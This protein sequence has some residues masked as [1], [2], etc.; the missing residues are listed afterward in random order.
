MRRYTHLLP[1][2][3]LLTAMPFM[4]G[5]V[6]LI[7]PSTGVENQSSVD[8]MPAGNM[9]NVHGPAMDLPTGDLPTGPV[10]L[11]QNPAVRDQPI[12]PSDIEDKKTTADKK[13]SAKKPAD[14]KTAEKEAAAK[15]KA[16]A[17]SPTKSPTKKAA[18]KPPLE[19]LGPE[20]EALRNRVR[21]AINHYSRQPLD[22][23]NNT[24]DH[25]LKACKAFGCDTVVRQGGASGEPLNGITCLCWNYSC[26][27][28]NL[29]KMVDGHIAARVG[30]GLQ[31]N[32]SE[33]LAVLALARVPSKYPI[34][35]GDTVRTVADLVESEKLDCRSGAD[36]SYRL[37]GLTR[38][39]KANAVWKNSL[40]EKWS[41]SRLLKEELNHAQEPSPRGGTNRLMA[42][43]YAIDRRA[44]RGLPI[45]GQFKR[46]KKYVDQY[47]DYALALQAPN[48]SWHPSFFKYRGEGGSSIDQI[49][50]TGHILAWL[51]SSLPD[52]ELDDPR[53]VR[54]VAFL[55]NMLAGRRQNSLTSSSGADIDARMNA[56]YALKVY[57]RRVFEPYDKAAAEAEAAEPDQSSTD[58]KT[59][60][61]WHK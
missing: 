23:Q 61:T 12:K 17:K 13:A 57:D 48:G 42:I 44:R 22:T 59:V 3:L 51:V 4:L 11:P 41:V 49:N 20:M 45:D 10:I 5:A 35:V 30:Y 32:P 18:A 31:S 19:P 21:Q 52:N 6:V 26:G 34:R 56:L 29:L 58:D 47:Q 46:A 27:G 55:S 50:S 15:T 36:N 37:I 14:Q 39:L 1:A 7:D 9:P 60:S 54:S 53:V 40:G 2:C 38:Y 24:A 28:Y 33:F 8:N 25:I 16:I 43:S